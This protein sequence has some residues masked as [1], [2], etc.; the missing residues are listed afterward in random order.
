MNDDKI[1]VMLDELRKLR[2]RRVPCGQFSSTEDFKKNFFSAA[3]NTRPCL[4]FPLWK[5]AASAAAVFAVLVSLAYFAFPDTDGDSKCAGNSLFYESLRLFRKDAGVICLNDSLITFERST[6]APAKYAYSIVLRD[7]N[8]K[9]LSLKLAASDDEAIRVDSP[10]LSGIILL[11]PSDD[12]MVVAEIELRTAKN[13]ILK[14]LC[15][16]TPV[17]IGSDG[18]PECLN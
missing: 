14:Q 6:S 1:A 11:I 10:E 13:T 8:G 7:G 4:A 17:R 5:I 18:M 12:S 16:V 9:K 3:G 15:A 2:E